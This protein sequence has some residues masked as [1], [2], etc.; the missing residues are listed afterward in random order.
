MI[1]TLFLILGCFALLGLSLLAAMILVTRVFP[2]F[3]FKDEFVAFWIRTHGRPPSR[4][5]LILNA[6]GAGNYFF[7]AEKCW[8]QHRPNAIR[9]VPNRGLALSFALGVASWITAILF[10]IAVF[11]AY[12][13][14][15]LLF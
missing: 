10:W 6:Y 2:I 8:D 7:M 1:A 15:T 5:R 14:L 11:V 3:N 9:L 4:R 12:S 13:Y